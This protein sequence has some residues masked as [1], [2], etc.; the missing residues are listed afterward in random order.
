MTTLSVLLNDT[1][2]AKPILN[3]LDGEILGFK[4]CS[5]V[6]LKAGETKLI[7]L[8]TIL[9]VPSGYAIMLCTMPDLANDNHT[10]VLGN[11]VYTS[12]NK[13]VV[14]ALVHNYSDRPVVIPQGEVAVYGLMFA[15]V[16]PVI[17]TTSSLTA[18]TAFY[19]YSAT[20][21]NATTNI[22]FTGGGNIPVSASSG[23]VATGNMLITITG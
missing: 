1:N 10:V 20:S 2:S 6:Y 15:Y 5:E 16:I 21:G 8:G 11:P 13:R 4:A 22:A 3:Y 23:S 7:N 12:D 9:D 14:K 19:L 18:T 17:E